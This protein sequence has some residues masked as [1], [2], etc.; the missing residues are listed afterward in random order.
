MKK[1]RFFTCLVIMVLCCFSFFTAHCD[2]YHIAASEEW[3]WEP[4]AYNT[5]TGEIDLSAYTGT[6]LTIQMS[7]DLPAEEE[8]GRNPVFT[9]IDGKRITVLRQSGT[10]FYTPDKNAPC[11]TFT[12]GI[13]LPVKNHIRRISFLFSIFDG[14]GQELDHVSYI[15]SA[16]EDG[17]GRADGVFYLPVHIGTITIVLLLAA[18]LV[19]SSFLV[20]RRMIAKNNPN[21]D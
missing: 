19:W 1:E 8:N 14:N 5:F 10:A 21:G 17:A 6:E 2:G 7:S 18:V 20:L 9:V 13:K 3:S 12:G 15:L 4:G 16:G 11:L